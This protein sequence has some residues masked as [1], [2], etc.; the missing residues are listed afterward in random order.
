VPL[1]PQRAELLWGGA[2][3]SLLMN[4]IQNAEAFSKEAAKSNPD[5]ARIFEEMREQ[6]STP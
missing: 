1:G 3:L 2:N 6:A 5:Y 4:S